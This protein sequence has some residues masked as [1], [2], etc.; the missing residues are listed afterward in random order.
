MEIRKTP[1]YYLGNDGL[2][3]IDVITEFELTYNVG[4]AVTYLL[5]CG[6]KTVSP[7]EDIEKAIHHLQYELEKINK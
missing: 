4:T 3:A 2:R 5:R 1:D 7:E 6:K